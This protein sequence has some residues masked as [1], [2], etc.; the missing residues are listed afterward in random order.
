VKEKNA[1]FRTVTFV[2]V[3]LFHVYPHQYSSNQLG[4]ELSIF[5]LA[6]DSGMVSGF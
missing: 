5:S 6:D 2:P 4:T 1:G 3:R